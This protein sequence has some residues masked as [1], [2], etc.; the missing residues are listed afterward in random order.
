LDGASFFQKLFFITLPSIRQMVS[1]III[2][3]MVGAVGTYQI[4]LA[5]TLGGP[6]GATTVPMIYILNMIQKYKNYG[7]GTTMAVTLGLILMA[8]SFAR[9]FIDR[10][11]T[12]K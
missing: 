2:L 12:A 7:Y 4:V 3:T 1:I 6:A 10:R 5:L 11:R 8:F 9:L